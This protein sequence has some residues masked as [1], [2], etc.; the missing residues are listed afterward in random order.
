MQRR[1]RPI[2]WFIGALLGYALLVM[3]FV[4]VRGAVASQSSGPTVPANFN[5]P[6][7][8]SPIAISADNALVWVVNPDDDSVSVIRTSNNTVIKKVGVGDEP[9][10]IAVDP[11]LNFVYVANA[12]DNTV[13][14]IQHN[15]TPAAF[16]ANVVS[17]LTTGA[18]PWNI[19]ISPNGQRV[20]VANSGQDTITIIDASTRGIIG[21]YNLATSPCNDHDN[22]GIGDPAYHFQPRGLAVTQNSD[23]LYV[24]QFLSFV[25]TGGVQATDT[26][27]QG[28]V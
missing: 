11:N 6:T 27:K 19:V 12:A 10:S 9:Q 14:V 25:K 15:N 13:T 21:N 1:K 26:G 23:R 24:T 3:A 28:V 18:E 2:L 8:S 22:N 5:P 17:T 7:Y 16:T 20:F 4:M